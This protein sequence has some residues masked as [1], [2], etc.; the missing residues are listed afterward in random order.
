M[1]FVNAALAF[2]ACISGR[3]L[4][5][6]TD[7]P[8]P[9]AKVTAAWTEVRGG[10]SAANAS[11]EVA[12]EA[13]TDSLG[14]YRVCLRPGATGL[15]HV[16]LGDANAYAPVTLGATDT[17][18]A[19]IRLATASDTGSATVTGRV[20]NEAGAPVARASIVVLGSSANTTTSDSGEYRLTGLNLGTQVFIVRRIGLG[21]AIIAASLSAQQPNTVGVTMQHLPPMLDVV[22]VV[23]DRLRLASV[24][25]AIGFNKRRRIGNGVFLNADEIQHRMASETPEIFRTVPGVQVVDD[26]RFGIRRVE[27]RR[28]PTTFMGPKDCTA[29]AIDGIAY[30]DGQAGRIY[31]PNGAQTEGVPDELGLP[32]PEELIAVEVYQPN[33]P[34]PEI[35]PPP[36]FRCLKIMLWTKA[37]LNQR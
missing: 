19:D 30:G 10:K 12:T 37:M 20:V 35:F 17:T 14:R 23:A 25:D 29:Y 6:D 21:A 26:H 5:V 27:S 15:V 3:V 7:Q 11:V 22:A 18:L 9:A 24:Y 1:I 16:H 13:T 2:G 34:S 36:A 8:M 32:V 4:H 28:G 33:E 31:F